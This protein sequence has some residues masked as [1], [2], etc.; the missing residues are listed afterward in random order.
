MTKTK[1]IDKRNRGALAREAGLRQVTFQ[2]SE[3]FHALL[4]RIA[5]ALG[6]N[7][8]RAIEE[9]GRKGAAI[10]LRKLGKIRD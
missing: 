9:I 7:Q 8:S 6:M 10:V 4:Q 2:V 3:E 1:R 5:D